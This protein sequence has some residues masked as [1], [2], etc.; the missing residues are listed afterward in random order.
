MLTAWIA[1]CIS[2]PEL[3][4]N[5]NRLTGAHVSFVPPKRTAFM[6]AIDDACGLANLPVTD[7]DE[8]SGFFA[9]CI[10]M[11]SRLPE[12]QGAKAPAA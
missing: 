1:M 3:V 6:A 11:F 4:E 2:S 12:F 5:Y 8:L 9:F 10:D 7:P